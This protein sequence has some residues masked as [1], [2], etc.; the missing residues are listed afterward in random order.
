MET[1]FPHLTSTS[2]RPSHRVVTTTYRASFNTLVQEGKLRPLVLPYH[3]YGCILLFLYLCI[4]HTQSPALYAARWPVLGLILAFQWKTLWEATS[5][6]MATGYAAGL[7]AAWGAVWSVTWLVFY[8]PQFDA[9]RVERRTRSGTGPV[10]GLG[11]QSNGD[12]RQ[13]N[14]SATGY[15]NGSAELKY[16]GKEDIETNGK[17]DKDA[18][19]ME[20]YWQ[21][22]PDNFLDRFTWTSDLL[23]NFR[24]PGWNWAIPPLPPLPPFIQTQLGEEVTPRSIS[25]KSSTGL[26]RYDT[27]ASLARARLPTFIAGY[28]LLDIL[29]VLMMKDPYYIFGPTSYALPPHL[30]RFRV[31]P[32]TLRFIRQALSS[33]AIFT[34]LEMTFLLAPLIAS[35]LL[36]PSVL[37]LRGE[38]YYYPTIWGSFSNITSKGLNGVWGGWWHQIF[39]FIFSAPS[40]YLINNGYVKAGSPVAKFLALVF[41]FGISGILHA[42]GSIS[43]FPATHPTHAPIFFMLQALGILLQ[44][45]ICSLFY[46][47]IKRF[48]RVIRQT[49]NFAFVFIWLFYTGWWLTD[50]FARGGIWLYEPIPVS[51]LRGLGFGDEG[52]GWWCWEHL[53]IGWYSGKHWWESGIAL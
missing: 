53:G 37:G 36:G 13:G 50:D 27:R 24:G 32:L 52:D 1:L 11:K 51:V 7:V 8:R 14:G 16:R 12:A 30:S 5:M 25:G 43:Q 17:L 44:M 18:G 26:Q 41:A 39:R 42:A 38:P 33:I 23:M 22:Y 20:Y 9:K 40:N 6:S 4:P 29:K 15:T 2:S 28:F 45:S 21:S 34:S 47:Q 35:L 3:L 19:A 31:S 49:G 46:A 10:S 48:P